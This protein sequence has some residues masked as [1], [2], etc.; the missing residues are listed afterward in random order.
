MGTAG[1]HVFAE[2][3]PFHG[4]ALWAALAG[5]GAEVQYHIVHST[6]VAAALTRCGQRW[7]WG[8]VVDEK[9]VP[10]VLQY[11]TVEQEPGAFNKDQTL[12]PEASALLAALLLFSVSGRENE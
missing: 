4:W 11:S 1:L 3:A 8:R 12:L 5:N 7:T 2:F 10:Y 6:V 9:V